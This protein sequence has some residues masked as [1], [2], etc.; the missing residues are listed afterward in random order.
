MKTSSKAYLLAALVPLLCGIGCDR[1]RARSVFR[2]GNKAYKEENYKKAIPLYERAAEL[3]PE[4]AEA[5]FYLGSS[6]QALFRP[7]KDTP[8]NK[9][10][11]EIALKDFEKSLEVNSGD[12]EARKKLKT[13][14]LGALIGIYSEDPFKKYEMAKKYADM[15]VNENPNDP[16]NLFAMAALLEKFD[17]VAEA[18]TMYRKVVELNS[19]DIKACGAL[20]AFYNKPLWDDQGNVWAEGSDRPRRARFDQ[21]IGTLERCASLAP[22][23]ASGFQKIATFYWDKAYRDPSLNDKQK[24]EY[25]DKGLENV[26][27]ALKLKPDYFEAV[28]FKGLLY[29]VK[30]GVTTNPRLR[31]QYLDQAANL[32]KQGL[33]LK[34][35]AMAAAPSSGAAPASPATPQ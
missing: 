33:E 7:G 29:R 20:A 17:K 8:D 23:D 31:Q 32:Q 18:E 14:T 24:D 15:L 25:A 12:T 27:K 10:H 3:N 2:D 4:M 6:H 30:A 16:K 34:K 19:K 26:D 1:V 5:F 13:N 28:I 22:D 9:E 11:L 21:A 35:E